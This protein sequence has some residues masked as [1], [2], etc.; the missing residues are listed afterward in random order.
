MSQR[1]YASLSRTS[2]HLLLFLAPAPL[3]LP[4]HHL[5]SGRLVSQAISGLEPSHLCLVHF[6]SMKSPLFLAVSRALWLSAHHWIFHWGHLLACWWLTQPCFLLGIHEL[7]EPLPFGS[8]QQCWVPRQSQWSPSG[9]RCA[10]LGSI[11]NETQEGPYDS[12]WLAYQALL[13]GPSADKLA[14]H[15]Q[16]AWKT[17]LDLELVPWPARDS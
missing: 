17:I 12:H 10:S 8:V 14:R 15:R 11:T 5:R 16:T 4:F 3:S 1:R 6:L 2:V 9:K 13:P 7:L